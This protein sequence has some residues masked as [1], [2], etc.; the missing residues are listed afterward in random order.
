MNKRSLA[1]TVIT[2]MAFI[3]NG[4]GGGCTDDRRY[5]LELMLF[6]HDTGLPMCNVSYKVTSGSYI[7][8]GVSPSEGELCNRLK[9]LE[10]RPGS[11][12]V[13]IVKEG[14][15]TVTF[16]VDVFSDTCHVVT[17]RR[18]IDLEEM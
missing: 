8:E 15:T 13:E 7:E 12:S 17:E 10:E 6:E 5:G 2:G 4:C 9:L 18:D 3:L 11:Y 1:V 14:Y 16:D